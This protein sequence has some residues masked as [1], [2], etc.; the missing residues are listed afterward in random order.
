MT[1]FVLEEKGGWGGVCP[2]RLLGAFAGVV[3]GQ[4]LGMLIED[5]VT[6]YFVCEACGNSIVAVK[7]TQTLIN[8]C[9]QFVPN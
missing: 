7:S 6:Y 4:G 3:C 8:A 2:A 5:K 1:L 9:P